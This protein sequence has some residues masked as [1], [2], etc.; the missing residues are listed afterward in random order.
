MKEEA[1]EIK[2]VVGV[3]LDGQRNK[4]VTSTMAMGEQKQHPTDIRGP[5]LH[6]KSHNKRKNRQKEEKEEEDGK[7]GAGRIYIKTKI[8]VW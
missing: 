2:E 5:K 3:V 7:E 6:E 4:V 8:K 1:R